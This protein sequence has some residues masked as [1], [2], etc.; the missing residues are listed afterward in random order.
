V[1]IRRAIV[2]V[3][4][5]GLSRSRAVIADDE[6]RFAI[7]NLPAGRFTLSASKAAHLTASYGARRPGRPGTPIL[8]AEGEQVDVIVPMARGA[9]VEGTIRDETG[10]PMPG[11]VVY[12]LDPRKP[13]ML[14][15]STSPRADMTTTDDRGMYRIFGLPPGE[16]VIAAALSV[17]G[18]GETGRRRDA[19]VDALLAS[20]AR[21][22]GQPA[23]P[24]L[25]P[26]PASTV[27]YP[28]TYYPGVAA[29]GSAERM[30][31]AAGDERVGL[32][33]PL[34]PLP[35][36][37]IEG[38]VLRADGAPASAVQLS[39][40]AEG[41]RAARFGTSPILAVPPRDDGRFKYTGIVAGH[42]TLYARSRPEPSGA[43]AGRAGLS[44][45]A[46]PQTGPASRL[47]AI[48]EFDVIGQDV[49]GLSLVLVP[50]AT[51]SGRVVFDAVSA[52]APEDLST[53]QLRLQRPGGG[54]SVRQGTM[55]GG[56]LVSVPP[57]PVRADG[58]FSVYDVAPGRYR[59]TAAVPDDIEQVWWLRSAM[60][61]GRDLLDVPLEM[62]T[63]NVDDLVLTFTDRRSELA[64]TLQSATG[65]PAPE[66]FVVAFPAERSLWLPESR[67][68]KSARPDTAGAFSL[69]DL[70]GGDYL[71][72]A[73]TDLEP[74][75][76]EDSAFLEELAAQAVAVRIVDG[77]RTVQDLRIARR[78]D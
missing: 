20:A 7:G 49:I 22:A 9:V 2:T 73:L 41:P 5:G 39:I 31:F 44:A 59:L 18:D 57:A 72:A 26:P 64:G 71:L 54:V 1:P 65:L 15:F 58:T 30:R 13:E 40:D 23:A 17:V 46:P 35:V 67:R 29:F 62:S 53:L 11:V 63:E 27:G 21:R 51:V 47:Y 61:G 77:E 43:P 32:D 6:G 75:D 45:N 69:R 16:Y 37:T 48:A 28:L 8:L 74:V 52:T 42:Y 66:Y 38:T 60:A 3:A 10:R 34:V 4:G 55:I 76:L 50:G 33:F 19:E 12:A 70:P 78:R 25:P 36:V 14:G 24:S 56:A 68:I